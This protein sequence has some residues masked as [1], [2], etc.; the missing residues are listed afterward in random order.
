MKIK[1]VSTF[2]NCGQYIEDCILSVK[3]QTFKNFE[4]FLIDDMS[5]DDTVEK[6]KKIIKDDSRFHLIVNEE[7]KYKL[8]NMDDLIT[9]ESFFDDEDVIVELDGDDKLYDSY[10]IEKINNKYLN[11]KNLWI[12]NGSF[13]FSDGNPGF[14]SKVNPFTIRKDIFRFSHLRTW[15]AHLWRSIDEE[16][17][18]GPDDEYFKSAPDVAYSFPMVEM[19]GLRHYEYIPDIMYV[20]NASSPFNENKPKSSMGGLNDVIKNE[21]FIRKMKSYNPI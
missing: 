2:W 19:A 7:K 3:N 20:Y 17:F 16:S 21:H 4:M 15:K 13:I 10:V 18:I 6:I 5:Q 14:S 11:N 8:K 12:T 1:I 9:D